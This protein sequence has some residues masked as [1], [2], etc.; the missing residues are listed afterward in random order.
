MTDYQQLAIDRYKKLHE[1]IRENGRIPKESED[2]SLLTWLI[3]M[4]GARR[5][6][7]NK[8]HQ[9]VWYPILDTLATSDGHPDLF[10]MADQ[11]MHAR[12]IK[13]CHDLINFMNSTGRS[14]N[15]YSDD[16]YE[17]KLS[18]W[19]CGM[20]FTKSRGRTK[21]K[22]S[23][24]RIFYPILQE[25]VENAGYPD[26]FDGG[27]K[28]TPSS[29]SKMMIEHADAMIEFVSANGRYPKRS[30]VDD[31]IYRRIIAYR[32]PRK[33]KLPELVKIRIEESGLPNMFS[34]DWRV[35]IANWRNPD[36]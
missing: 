9:R 17:F 12:A 13:R 15:H 30:E 23:R 4:R 3:K 6:Y 7:P 27:D 11:D 20:K 5:I 25:M 16:P 31:R 33:L 29:L 1:F 35:D 26:A 19:L 34:R 32:Q 22:M 28:M 36:E 18:N 14:P 8:S 2:D 21:N 24:K 10:H